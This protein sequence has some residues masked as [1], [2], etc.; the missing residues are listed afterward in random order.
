MLLRISLFYLSFRLL[1]LIEA[2]TFQFSTYIIY[3]IDREMQNGQWD[4]ADR[5]FCSISE[6]WSNL[7]C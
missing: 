6:V 1:L 7:M 5:L 2:G 4:V 3:N